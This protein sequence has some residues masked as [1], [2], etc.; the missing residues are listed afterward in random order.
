MP[1]K[2]H[3]TNTNLCR[4]WRSKSPTVPTRQVWC[5][6]KWTTHTP[7]TCPS[8]S[9]KWLRRIN[10]RASDAPS[11]DPTAL[12]S[13]VRTSLYHFLYSEQLDSEEYMVYCTKYK[14]TCSDTLSTSGGSFSTRSVCTVFSDMYMLRIF[15]FPDES[16]KL[17]IGWESILPGQVKKEAVPP[18]SQEYLQVKAEFKRTSPTFT[19]ISVCTCVVLLI[20]TLHV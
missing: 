4:T 16:I 6:H 2:A 20:R 19:I 10:K 17:P 13:L 15:V 3:S 9:N 7:L 5:S 14:G 12:H 1:D 11:V 18:N 8:I